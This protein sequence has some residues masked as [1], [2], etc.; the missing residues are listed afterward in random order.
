MAQHTITKRP[1]SHGTGGIGTLTNPKYVYDNNTN[2]YAY[3]TARTKTVFYFPSFGVPQNSTITKVIVY[4]KV[5]T[6]TS[7]SSFE[8]YSFNTYGSGEINYFK[9]RFIN[10]AMVS[11]R[12]YEAEITADTITSNLASTSNSKFT[13]IVNFFNTSNSSQGFCMGTYITGNSPREVRIYDLYATLYY[14]VPDYTIT[15]KAGEGGTVSG[16]G[17][18]ESGTNATLRAIPNNGYKFVK[19]SDGN[20]S[21]SRTITVTGNATYTAY[22]EL[23]KIYV[24][25]D[26]IFNFDKWKDSGITSGNTATI[27]NITNTGFS[28]TANAS[29]SYTNN[30]HLFTV[31]PNTN[32]I[33]EYDAVGNGHEAYVFCDGKV[34]AG[35][36]WN[37]TNGVLRFTVPSDCTTIAIRC[38]SNVSG[39]TIDYSNI[40]IYPADYSY[41]SNSVTATNRSCVNSWNFPTPTRTGYDFL[42]WNTKPDGSGTTYNSS[43]SF[44][45]SDL[46]LY[47][48][49]KISK[50]NK[51]Y[52]GTSQPKSI[53]VGTSEV[54]AVYVGTTK[55]YG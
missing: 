10:Q 27:S 7:T 46:V 26:S 11:A 34:V 50:I 21:A 15:V 19:W 32:Y 36:F 12:Y 55:V 5:S 14:T 20:T 9:Q 3:N 53:Y 37:T 41:M 38:D 18:I 42:G 44:P 8:L 47:S 22:F 43:S 40:R 2:T 25:F 29:D 4:V 33:L 1:I 28:I 16:G 23:D 17:V 45:T 51:I 49:W 39:N 24:T 54:K 6:E 30:S 48:Q 35:R 52:I 31:T 13:N